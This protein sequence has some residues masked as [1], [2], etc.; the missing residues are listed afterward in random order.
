MK[1]ASIDIETSGLDPQWCAV[2]EFGCIIDD[3]EVVEPAD[4][5]PK[6]HRYLLHERIY[7]EPF[8]LQMNQAILKKIALFDGK[9]VF[10]WDSGQTRFIPPGSLGQEFAFWLKSNDVDPTRVIAAGKNFASFDRRFLATVPDFDTHVKF[11][12]RVVDPTSMYLKVDDHEPPN[13]NVCAIRA[14]LD[15]KNYEQH[16]ALGDAQ[17]VIDLIRRAL[18][19]DPRDTLVVPPYE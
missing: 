18:R 10:D 16:T 19:K 15:P 6:F 11:K 9:N 13:T 12:H 3:L 7:G 8:A 14:G 17:M 4:K 2:L 1:I 5:L